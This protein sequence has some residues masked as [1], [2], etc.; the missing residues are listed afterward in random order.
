MILLLTDDLMFSIQIRDVAKQLGVEIQSAKNPEK[1]NELINDSKLKRMIVDLHC[2]K[3]D[4]N[5]C[6]HELKKT[7]PQI[8]VVAFFS[9]VETE[10]AIQAK[11]A[12]AD[13]V[14]ARSR[15]VQKLAELL[16]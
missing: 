10:S 2:K 1:F 4:P 3:L 13:Q 14:M 12:G 5:K 16:S 9:H 6:I 8:E 15:F 7:N 11:A